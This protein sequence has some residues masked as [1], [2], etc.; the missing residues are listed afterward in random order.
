MYYFS[1]CAR[2]NVHCIDMREF[3]SFI[4][5]SSALLNRMLF[6]PCLHEK[7]LF[8]RFS[9]L[10]HRKDALNI[11]DNWEFTPSNSQWRVWAYCTSHR[12][13]FNKSTE[14]KRLARMNTHIP[15]ML[16]ADGRDNL[17]KPSVDPF[18]ETLPTINL[19]IGLPQAHTGMNACLDLHAH[20]HMLQVGERHQQ[21]KRQ[22]AFLTDTFKRE[23]WVRCEWQERTAMRVGVC[24]LG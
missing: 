13:H 22:T 2:R 15:A 6:S 20:A 8:K 12:Q 19:E 23:I 18:K 24:N 3:S 11:M 1:P 21:K 17:G 14:G 9:A 5:V 7:F 16:F 4:S 10:D